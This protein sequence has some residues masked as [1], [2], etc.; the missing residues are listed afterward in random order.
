MRRD[1]LGADLV[2]ALWGLTLFFVALSLAPIIE[3]FI[4]LNV[5]AI[6]VWLLSF[7]LQVALLTTM[8]MIKG[9]RLPFGIRA[10]YFVSSFGRGP[11]IGGFLTLFVPVFVLTLPFVLALFA[12]FPRFDLRPPLAYRK[13][14]LTAL[15]LSMIAFAGIGLIAGST[16]LSNP[17]LASIITPD[18][19]IVEFSL[20]GIEIR[21]QTGITKMAG[22]NSGRPQ[23]AGGGRIV[24]R[25]ADGLHVL[26]A[27][28]GK[29]RLIY[30]AREGRPT[31]DRFWVCGDQVLFS[32]GGR[33]MS[34]YTVDL[35]SS[36]PR[37]F[38]RIS[39]AAEGLKALN[40]K[41]FGMGTKDGLRFW[42]FLPNPMRTL[43]VRVWEDG[44]TDRIVNPTPVPYRS[45]SYVNGLV[46]LQTAE[47]LIAY[48]ERETG[49]AIIKR[50]ND[51]IWFLEPWDE[52]VMELPAVEALYGTQGDHI[53]RLDL[54][55]WEIKDIA[56]LTSRRRSWI[57]AYW[58]DLFVLFEE[59][60]GGRASSVSLIR[61]NR[62]GRARTFSY[63]V[64][65][66]P[67]RNGIISRRGKTLRVVAFPDFSEI[68]I[69]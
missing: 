48:G 51:G 56:P 39:V 46:I 62:L 16:A 13:K 26:N 43:P 21:D 12:A 29:A 25:Q 9:L 22:L 59:D 1:V 57:F 53:A 8:G 11:V 7:P 49:F 32:D 35:E 36:M 14:Y 5:T 41:P 20:Y 65:F 4:V 64:S 3:N 69:R 50:L 6:F 61:N 66:P 27:T 45:A 28:A 40:G 18:D 44:R 2:V 15:F 24:Y 38:R 17:V 60:R 58:P 47:G 63:D 31:P 34:L 42:W 68:D 23:N 55:T 33:G 19:R 37:S 30:D 10:A 52:S 67:Q 54:K